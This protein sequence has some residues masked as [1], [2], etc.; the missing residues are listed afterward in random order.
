[1]RW[2]CSKFTSLKHLLGESSMIP[3]SH[4]IIISETKMKLIY[5]FFYGIQIISETTMKLIYNFFYG[6]Q[7]F[8][9]PFPAPLYTSPIKTCHVLT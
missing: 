5:N 1:M 8:C 3:I 2:S 7:I 9:P 4:L 6:I